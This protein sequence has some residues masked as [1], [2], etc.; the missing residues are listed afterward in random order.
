MHELKDFLA[1]SRVRYRW[2]DVDADSEKARAIGGDEAIGD[3]PLPVLLL[4]DGERLVDPDVSTLAEKLGLVTE[5]ELRDYD[6]IVIGGGPAGLTTSIY[7]ASEGLRTIVIERGA[8]GGQASYSERIENYPGFP[9][10]LSG[11]DFAR[12]TVLQAE[13][14]GVE[15]IVTREATGLKV[16]GTHRSV[17]L[18]DFTELRATSILLATG[19]SFRWLDA[20]GCPSL[21]GAGIYYGEVSA[22][23]SACRD[24][25]VYVLGGGNAA[26]QAAL[27]LARYAK[28]VVLV[29]IEDSLDE[30]MSAYL[31]ERIE[32]QDNITVRTG[33]TITGAEGREHLEWLTLSNAKSGETERVPAASLFVFIGATPRTD[34]LDGT[35]ARD[36]QGFVL[37]GFDYLEDCRRPDGWPLKRAPY[38]LE[39][40]VPGVFVAGDARRGSVKRLTSATGEG[41]MAAQMIHRYCTQPDD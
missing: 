18:D 41:A 28:R 31:I 4:P 1:R 35:V 13:R 39:T 26:G 12:R 21:V 3:A 37:S 16:N 20:P 27:L 23:A 38:P 36:E 6:L 34:W 2:F 22:E 32:A 19:A 17:S 7:T 24:Q 15:V 5:A 25:D 30:Q 40:S 11:I 9:D 10:G 29:A 8:A 14:F 33:H